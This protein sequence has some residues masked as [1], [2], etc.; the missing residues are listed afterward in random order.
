MKDQDL[1]GIQFKDIVN[2][3]IVVENNNL[4]E[5]ALKLGIENTDMIPD[6]IES[7]K[8][9]EYLNY[10]ELKTIYSK[11]LNI[12]IDEI[13]EEKYSKIEKEDISLG[14]N[15]VEA[16]GYQIKLKVK[17]IQSIY[18]KILEKAKDDEQVFNLINKFNNEDITFE[19]YQASIQ[20]NLDSMPEIS[21]EENTDF[22]SISVYKQGKNT[23]KLCINLVEDE[24]DNIELSIE[25]TSNGMILKFNDNDEIIFDITKTSNSQEQEK[26]ECVISV[27]SNDEETEKLNINLSRAGAL[28]SNNVIFDISIP[29]TSEDASVNI[30]FKNT[31]NFSA[32]PEFEE[33]NE[34]NHLVINGLS[35]EQINNLF[36]NL[37]NIISE[38]FQNEMFISTISSNIN[39]MQS[40]M[41]SSQN[42]VDGAQSAIEEESTISDS[43]VEV[44]GQMYSVDE[45]LNQN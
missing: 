1:Y 30:E 31:S 4:K 28:T 29:I 44:D 2:Q 11:Y 24:V 27:K 21:N 3:Y 18:T 13:P 35:Q 34:N 10:E 20:E 15:T 9:S 41:Q 45:Y 22:I 5:L 36:T 33:F 8:V 39:T 17:D 6:R 38:K 42:T 32:V 14:D 40:M 25:K 43:M 12:A 37:K 23:I 7:T 16:D 26:F 19:D